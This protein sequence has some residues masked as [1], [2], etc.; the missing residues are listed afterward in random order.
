MKHLT[1]IAAL[2]MAIG[3]WSCSSDEPA[4]GGGD[5]NISGTKYMAVRIQSVPDLG[6]R[7]VAD[8]TKFEV[9]EGNENTL[10]AENL[11][12][13]FFTTDGKPFFMT[14]S[15]VD[16][17][18]S[19]NMVKPNN[20][21]SENTN[22][23]TS[24]SV[25][26]TLVLDGYEGNTPGYV[27]CVANL[28]DN[29]AYTNL[30]N[31][32]L[33]AFNQTIDYIYNIT[34]TSISSFVMTSSTYLGSDSKVVNYT[35]IDKLYDDVDEAKAN[36]VNIFVERLAAKIRVHAD[37]TSTFNSAIPV[38]KKNADGSLSKESFKIKDLPE[39]KN[40]VAYIK[41]WVPFRTATKSNLIKQISTSWTDDNLFAAWNNASL[42]RSYWATTPNEVPGGNSSYDI[43]NN[44]SWIG[45]YTTAEANKGNVCYVMENTKGGST[46]YTDNS[47][48]S[49]R[50][51][52]D[53]T[54]IVVR[55]QICLEGESAG[56]D[57]IRWGGEYYTLE[58]FKSTIVNAYNSDYT[59]ANITADNVNLVLNEDTNNYYVTVN[60]TKYAR[61]DKIEW[62]KKGYTCYQVN[63]E[64]FGMRLGVVRNHIYDFAINQVIGL[65]VPGNKP[66]DPNYTQSYL[67]AKVYVL[68]WR[69]VTNN[70]T[71]Q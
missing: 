13:Y 34:S 43:H 42:H 27:V 21:S 9:G 51:N 49:A 24:T 2:A 47:A 1:K 46:K 32:N 38:M 30:S 19:S 16:G 53:V 60:G 35:A 31:K 37:G 40:L 56:L 67:A 14:G 62:W 5:N 26:A 17:E 48:L 65:G 6:S 3:L 28:K 10:T 71:L 29:A 59:A 4:N 11:R 18:V 52:K 25:D 39:E 8:D 44:D 54:S 36:P 33:D 69:V 15:G 50:D 20:I 23:G 61:F 64:H 58:F 55:A 57:F 22:G 45:E 70:I 63:I 41:G 12:F 7:A 68:N 66:E